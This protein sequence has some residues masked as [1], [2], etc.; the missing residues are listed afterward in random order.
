[1]DG[2]AQIIG[3]ILQWQLDF[4]Q[5]CPV[6]VAPQHGTWLCYMSDTKNFKVDDRRLENLCTP[7]IMDICVSV[8]CVI[9]RQSLCNEVTHLWHVLSQT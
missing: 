7:L 9:T 8:T 2:G 3:A 4:V 1:M 6:L 5:W